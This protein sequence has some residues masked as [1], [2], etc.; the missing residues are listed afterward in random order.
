MLVTHCL[1]VFVACSLA[2][3]CG[4][5]A[6]ASDQ[7]KQA[8]T[9]KPKPYSSVGF[10]LSAES[11]PNNF[12]GMDCVRVAAALKRL[13]LNKSQFETTVI[14]EQRLA[15]LKENRLLYGA[16]HLGDVLAFKVLPPLTTNYDA[17]TA[18]LTID[19][20]DGETAFAGDDT[21]MFSA[22][23]VTTLDASQSSYVGS[24]AFGVKAR[25]RRTTVSTCGVL[26]KE[27]RFLEPVKIAADIP[28]AK[29]LQATLGMLVIGRIA[30]P[31]IADGVIEHQSATISEPVERTVTV[32][33]VVLSLSEI[34]YYDVQS[35]RI[36]HRLKLNDAR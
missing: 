21:E 36:H 4:A 9:A 18:V 35:G 24:N 12:R 28:T 29:R 11:L 1:A 2:F 5:A 22:W 30:P 33:G 25:V 7:A 8:A 31:F 27:T 17:D 3:F 19:D 14:Y 15:H 6:E 32:T 20:A 10:D 13:P 34:W 26:E 23:R 16:I